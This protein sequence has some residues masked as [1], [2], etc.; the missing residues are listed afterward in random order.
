MYIFTLSFL[1]ENLQPKKILVCDKIV[2]FV[3]FQALI[4][5]RSMIIGLEV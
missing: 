2:I 4:N 5:L 3:D 1:L